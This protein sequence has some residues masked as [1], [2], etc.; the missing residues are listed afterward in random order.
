MTVII[1]KLQLALIKSFETNEKIRFR[2]VIK[3]LKKEI[4]YI[5]GKWKI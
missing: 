3:N 4:E 5:T 1:N 2:K